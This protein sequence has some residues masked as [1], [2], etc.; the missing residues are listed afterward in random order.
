VKVLTHR[1]RFIKPASVP[2]FGDE[3]STATEA[4][5]PAP[6][7]KN[8]EPAIMPKA[9]NIKEIEAAKTKIVEVTSPSAGITVPKAQKDLTATPKRKRMVNVLDVLETIKS[10][11]TTPKKPAEAPKT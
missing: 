7:Q 2:K 9:N 11:S 3:T 4:K 5:G 8:E 10:S 6:T 1:P